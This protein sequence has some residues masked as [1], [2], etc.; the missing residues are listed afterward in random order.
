MDSWAATAG[1]GYSGTF[2]TGPPAARWIE[3]RTMPMVSDGGRIIGHSGIFQD[4]TERWAAQRRVA[5][6]DAITRILANADTTDIACRMILAE[7]GETLGWDFGVFWETERQT[8]SLRASTVWRKRASALDAFETTARAA[9]F[10]PGVGLPGRVW[11]A[12]EPAWICDVTLDRN[13]PRAQE[14]A[15]AG[16]HGAF[17]FPITVGGEIFGVM[18]FYSRELWGRDPDLLQ[19]FTVVGSQIGQFIYRKKHEHDLRQSEE[20]F[21]RVAQNIGEV[22]WIADPAVGRVIY[23][24]PAY[25]LIWGRTCQSI[26]DEG[27]SFLESIHPADRTR[28]AEFRERSFRGERSEEVCRIVRPDGAIRWIRNLAFPVH[29]DTGAVEHVAGLAVDITEH[30]QWEQQRAQAAKM[31]A[32]GVLAGGLAHDFN[33]L[34]T[35]ILGNAGLALD[36][37]GGRHPATGLLRDVISSS[38][39][40]AFLVSQILA[41]SGK[42]RFFIELLDLSIT[43]GDF[44]E[45]VAEALPANV[46]LRTELARGLPRLEADRNQLRQLIANLYLNAV[47][48]IGENEGT[49]TIITGSEAAGFE[50][51]GAGG[52]KSCGCG[53]HVFLRVQDTGCGIEEAV[54]PRIFDPFFTT[55]FV[56]RGLGL[57]AAHGIVH[58]HAGVI[59]VD[60]QLGAGTTFTCLFPAANPD[61]E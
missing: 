48:A 1:L 33:N 14:A 10:P 13:F 17:A 30:V 53:T 39:R 55:K 11:L 24:S 51:R 36:V 54:R 38:E 42:G 52:D 16:L 59:R 49:I 2:G 7:I 32:L 9:F 35:T 29:T 20:R 46:Q 47:E 3:V 44:L 56:G 28:A 12:R 22:L 41:Y 25:E 45:E 5:I 6:R 31:D 37:V 34:L 8:Q 15:L 19:L 58:A 43:T 60:S 4:V 40:A 18:E 26:F 21:W 57:S 27:G 50:E 61:A 23:V